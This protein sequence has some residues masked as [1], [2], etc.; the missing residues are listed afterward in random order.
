METEGTQETEGGRS[1]A[2]VRK[3]I[4]TSRRETYGQKCMNSH[5]EPEC[6]HYYPT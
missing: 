2:A 1:P 3:H 4:C 5:L 6:K